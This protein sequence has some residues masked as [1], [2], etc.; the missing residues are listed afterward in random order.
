MDYIA[1]GLHCLGS[2]VLCPEKAMAP[3]SSTLAWKIPGMGELGGLPSMGSHRVRHN[4]SDLAAA[5]LCPPFM[6]GQYEAMTEDWRA[7]GGKNHRMSPS[8]CV[9]SLLSPVVT[10]FLLKFS[11]LQK[12]PSFHE[13]H[14]LLEG[15]RWFALV[16]YFLLLFHHLFLWLQLSTS[17][18]PSP[19]RFSI[20]SLFSTAIPLY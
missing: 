2:H 18:C 20:L 13:T 4:W 3:H 16:T 10:T 14:F 1:N 7:R 19:S 5:V 17:A 8:L 11:S 12:S 15:S 9:C 6:F